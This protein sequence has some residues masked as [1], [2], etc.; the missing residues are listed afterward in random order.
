MKTM[1]LKVG[2]I[3]LILLFAANN[4][5]AQEAEREVK[6]EVE[7][8]IMMKDSKMAVKVIKD[9]E[10]VID[11]IYLM[12]KNFDKEKIES[13]INELDG[14]V[15]T[16]N[17]F[18]KGDKD[19]MVYDFGFDS[20]EKGE[21]KYEVI[22]KMGQG[23]EESTIIITKKVKDGD[24]T[25]EQEIE[26]EVIVGDGKEGFHK[27]HTKEGNVMFFSDDKKHHNIKSGNVVVKKIG[28]DPLVWT[29]DESQIIELNELKG[30]NG[31]MMF[32]AKEKKGQI[33]LDLREDGLYRLGFDS[34][35][36]EPILIEV[37]D[38]EGNRL[39]KKK[40]KNFYGR[41]LKDVDLGNNETGLY[42]VRV[43]QGEKEII[44]EFEYN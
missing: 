13:M 29:T 17:I 24:E 16:I 33:S 3:I 26:M 9:G 6:K 38:G 30:K 14:D 25:E 1:L 36:L 28:E 37:F 43:V 18:K 39:F 32:F 34:G 20:D 22:K 8:T 2:A 44:G 7:K 40:V 27:F 23:E 41:F 21:G 11:T 12:D 5:N 42:T 15:K 31:N 19:V 4:L 10:T 35:E